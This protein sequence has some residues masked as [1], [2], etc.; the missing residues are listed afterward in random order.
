L[1]YA[2]KLE[3]DI[4]KFGCSKC[5]IQDRWRYSEVEKDLLKINVEEYNNVKKIGKA[6]NKEHSKDIV[7]FWN[8]H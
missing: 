8:S 2:K 5:P 1:V 6:F 4:E 7:E 3:L